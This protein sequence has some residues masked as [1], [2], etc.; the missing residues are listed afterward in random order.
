[1]QRLLLLWLTEASVD[2]MSRRL[3]RLEA[4]MR[5][6]SPKDANRGE[7]GGDGSGETL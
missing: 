2:D 5:S 7:E 1:M 4:R 6:E 3:D